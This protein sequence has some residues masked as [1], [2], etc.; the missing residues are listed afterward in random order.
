MTLV[1]YSP[2]QSVSCRLMD[3]ESLRRCYRRP[4][5]ASWTGYGESVCVCLCVDMGSGWGN[6]VGSGHKSFRFFSWSLET[7][8]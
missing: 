8:T 7:V 4:G 1:P 6:Q 2:A 3:E 5:E